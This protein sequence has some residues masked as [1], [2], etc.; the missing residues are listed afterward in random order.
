M[1]NGRGHHQITHDTLMTFVR[2]ALIGHTPRRDV[3]PTAD[4]MFDDLLWRHREIHGHGGL[5]IG[6][7]RAICE[8]AHAIESAV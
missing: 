1:L 4:A 8:D 7:V 6:T 5:T 2:L 3:Q